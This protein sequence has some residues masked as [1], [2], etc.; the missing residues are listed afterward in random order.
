MLKKE[1]YTTKELLSVFDISIEPNYLREIY[2]PS[3]DEFHASVDFLKEYTE[4]KNIPL[5]IFE[6]ETELLDI[7]SFFYYME[8]MKKNSS[9]SFLRDSLISFS[10]LNDFKSIF[11]DPFYCVCLKLFYESS[12]LKDNQS[13]FVFINSKK[14]NRNKKFNT[15]IDLYAREARK[16][17]ISVIF[18]N[19]EFKKEDLKCEKRYFI[20]KYKSGRLII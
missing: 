15:L 9:F 13:M 19:T 18:L 12:K 16:K 3:M 4:N 6:K 20:S 5:T 7:E 11:Q 2:Y 17:G 14:E 10:F 1:Y 8:E